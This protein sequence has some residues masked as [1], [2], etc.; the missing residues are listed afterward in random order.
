MRRRIERRACGGV[1]KKPLKKV[2]WRLV[3]WGRVSVQDLTRPAGGTRKGSCDWS[4]ATWKPVTL[5]T[6]W[7]GSSGQEGSGTVAVL[8]RTTV[9]RESVAA[10][11]PAARTT[12][13]ARQPARAAASGNLPVAAF[14]PSAPALCESLAMLAPL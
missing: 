14:R 7:Q 5:P 8:P 4:V 2:R 9:A 10:P 11:A 1:P 13:V 3:G 12:R 6:A